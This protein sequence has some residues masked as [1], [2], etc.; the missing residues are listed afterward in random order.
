MA[1]QSK[2]AQHLSHK[3]EMPLDTLPMK[4]SDRMP[5]YVVVV[6]CCCA[7]V[8]AALGLFDLFWAEEDLSQDFPKLAPR[9]YDSI[10][11]PVWFDVIVCLIGIGIMGGV[12]ANYLRYRKI[13]F[14]GESFKIIDRL[15]SGKKITY[16]DKLKNYEGVLLRI[17]F[18]QRGFIN[19]NRYIIEALHKDNR[20]TVPLFIAVSPKNMRQKW[21]FFAKKLNL[22]ALMITNEG[23]VKRNAEDLD[24]SLIEL[25]KEGKIKSKYDFNEPLPKSVILVRKSD[26]KIIKVA[27]VL[28]DA[29]TFIGWGIVLIAAAMTAL[30]IHQNGLN[31]LVVCAALIICATA[32]VLYRRDKIAIKKYKFVIVHKFPFKNKKK[33][34]INKAEIEDIE[35][36]QNPASERYYLVISSQNKSLLFGKKLPPED[37]IW[38][39]NYLVNDLIK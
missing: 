26:K 38:I 6:G 30:A 36:M 15:R 35:V 9:G 23:I 27:K 13:F 21:K 25:Y 10:L 37:L 33:G 18:L 7:L 28:C 12:I 8:L 34:E 17:E 20:K 31:A 16:Q 22:P 2:T 29:Y 1:K 5:F 19:C 14:D 24:K 4:I 32:V 3:F 11:S 39:K